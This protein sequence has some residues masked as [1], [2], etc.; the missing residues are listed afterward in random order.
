[1]IHFS[2]G[3]TPPAKGFWSI[4]MYDNE[5]FFVDNAIN[6]YN[7]GD[8]TVGLKN[9]TDGSLDVYIQHENPGK[10]KESNW[11]PAPNGPFN[12]L[13][14]MYIPDESVLSGQYKFAPIVKVIGNE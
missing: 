7:I 3:Q 10:E 8:N 14:R 2:H 1:M 13:L 9:S 12:L 5:G 4:T 6:R 11:L